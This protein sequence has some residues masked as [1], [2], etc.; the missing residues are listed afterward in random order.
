MRIVLLQLIF[1]QT[2][3]GKYCS[4]ARRSMYSIVGI[5]DVMASRYDL[6][7]RGPLRT[8]NENWNQIFTKVAIGADSD[9]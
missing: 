9:V 5:T 3:L 6:E 4:L 1:S 2:E 8:N 7:M